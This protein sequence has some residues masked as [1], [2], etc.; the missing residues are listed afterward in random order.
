MGIFNRSGSYTNNISSRVF[1]NGVQ[2]SGYSNSNSEPVSTN[3]VEKILPL[4]GTEFDFDICNDIEISFKPSNDQ[5][6]IFRAF[7][8]EISKFSLMQ[9]GSTIALEQVQPNARGKFELEIHI[10]PKSLFTIKSG[11]NTNCNI[12][13]NTMNDRF[14]GIFGNDCSFDCE[15]GNLSSKKMQFG[16]NSQMDMKFASITTG[17]ILQGATNNNLGLIAGTVTNLSLSFQNNATVDV[18][19]QNIGTIQDLDIFNDS[20]FRLKSKGPKSKVSSIQLMNNS[21]V[22]LEN[23]EAYEIN[24]R[25]NTTLNL[26]NSAVQD[27]T[28]ANNAEVNLRNS[29]C[30][31]HSKGNNSTIQNC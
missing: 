1:V 16:N 10:V 12:P 11:N 27:L 31:R 28:L 25:N 24:A 5:K 19:C 7:E 26:V 29:T 8:S 20:A 9:K 22:T 23:L 13:I 6:V 17:L 14:V 18:S 15:E 4:V 21:V 2:V 30:Q 3:V